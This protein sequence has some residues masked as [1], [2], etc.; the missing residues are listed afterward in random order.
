MAFNIGDRVQETTIT[1]GTGT[2]L[3]AGAVTG[4]QSF[5]VIGNANTTYYTIADQAGSN[6]EVGIGTYY[7]AN[8]SLA[9][10]T[11]LASSNSNAAVTFGT[12]IKNVF[13]TYPAEKAIYSDD[14]NV[15]TITNIASANAVITGGTI[16]NTSF[17]NVSVVS[18]NITTANVTTQLNLTNASDY[19]LYASGAGKNYMAGALGIGTVPT[20]NSG[21]IVGKAITGA[22]SAYAYSTSATINSDVTTLGASY[23]SSLSTQAAAFTLGVAR[24]FSATNITI[25]AT[26]AVTT[27]VGFVTAALSGATNNYAFQGGVAAATGR[28]NLYM[29]G[30]ADNYMAGSLGIGGLPSAG[31]ILSVAKNVTGAVNAYGVYNS[32]QIQ[33]DVT[34][35]YSNFYSQSFTAAAAFTLGNYY[36]FRTVQGPIG[37]GSAITNQYGY[38]VDSTLTGATNNYG[39]RSDLAAASGVWNL[40][41]NGTANNYLAGSLGIGNTSLTG[42]SLAIN[43]NLTGSTSCTVVESRGQIQSSVTAAAL[44]FDTGLSTQAASFTLGTAIHYRAYQFALGASSAITTQYGFIADATLNAATN[45]WAF[46]GGIAAGTGKYNLYMNGTAANYLAGNTLIGSYLDI[47]TNTTV[48]FGLRIRADSADTY[49]GIQFTN[50]VVSAQWARIISPAANIIA[51]MDG[52]SVEKAR[53]DSSGNFVVTGSG[54]LGYGTGSGGA[55]TQGT[56][57]TTGVTLNKTNG[58]I[59]LFS[60]AGTTAYQSFTVTNSTVAATDTVIV[61]QKSSTDLYEVFITAVAAGSFRITYRT[62]GGTTTEQP[63]FNFAVIKAVV[64]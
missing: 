63:V 33:S 64:A 8:T 13:V 27:Q 25:G 56:S 14:N 46:V 31:L 37:A 23:F 20:A 28:Y 62:T 3:L 11:I 59:T 10:T 38:A 2:V 1:T 45:N 9:R 42:I 41:M 48:A 54:G 49:A 6:W 58:A 17:N 52:G 47:T 19:N 30:T 24:H 35:N 53:L 34:S 36:H 5:A 61:S 57:R 39:F 12:G 60:A 43:K 32:G 29:G 26:S 16:N 44:Y 4:F 40:Y 55:V 22:T 15:T 18:A 21:L 7:L 51:F 50:N